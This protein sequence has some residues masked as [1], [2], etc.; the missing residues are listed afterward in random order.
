MLTEVTKGDVRDG[1]VAEQFARRLGHEHLAAVPCRGDPRPAVDTESDIALTAHRRLARVDAHADTQLSV[2]GPRMLGEAELARDRA[3]DGVLGA[4]E[5]DEERVSLRVDLVAAVLGERLAEDPLVVGERPTVDV[6]S[7]L[8]EQ[9]RGSF[10]VCEQEG[11]GADGQFV[12]RAHADESL[13]AAADVSTRAL[14]PR[15]E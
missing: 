4:P 6:A 8:F 5:G 12:D 11:D 3:G 7:Q 14:S 9:L 15:S 1:I 2:V 13:I 10:D